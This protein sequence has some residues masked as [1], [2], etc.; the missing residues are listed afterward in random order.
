[1]PS[2]AGDD[3]TADDDM[4]ATRQMPAVQLPAPAEIRVSQ[5]IIAK[6]YRVMRELGRGT[7]GVVY[8]C[9]DL[10][11][12]QR[13]VVVKRIDPA[14]VHDADDLQ[15]RFATEIETLSSLRHP[16]I[17]TITDAGH[18]PD[19]AWFAMDLVDGM[20]LDQWLSETKPP[21]RATLQ[22]LAD[23]A[24]AVAY[25]HHRGVIHCD[26]KPDN[27][28]ID[29]EGRP[30]VLDFGLAK[31]LQ[32][33]PSGGFDVSGTPAYMAPEQ[34]RGEG[35][36]KASDCW[37]LGAILILAAT[38]R[39]PFDPAAPIETTL[40]T[41]AS[42]RL[43]RLTQ[44][45]LDPKLVQL[46]EQC[47][48]PHA[49]G[50]PS[51]QAI[52]EQ[53]SALADGQ[54]TEGL[55][56]A[57]TAW[58]AWLLLATAIVVAVGLI[59]LPM[60]TSSSQDWYVIAHGAGQ[61]TPAECEWL[62][63]FM[64]PSDEPLPAN[65]WLWFERAALGQD[66][67]LSFTVLAPSSHDDAVEIVLDAGRETGGEW[68]HLPPARLVKLEIG[69]SQMIRVGELIEGGSP[70]QLAGM[71]A[72]L[73]AG[74]AYH[75][76][77]ETVE[78]QLQVI[79]DGA[80]IFSY[81]SALP[82]PTGERSAVGLRWFK[83]TTEISGITIEQ[84]DRT[85]YPA[86]LASADLLARSATPTAAIARY[87][88][89]AAQYPDDDRRASALARAAT[90]AVVNGQ[91]D[92][93]EQL[94][95]QIE[96]EH[97]GDPA[98]DLAYQGLAKTYWQA[99]L[100]EQALDARDAISDRPLADLVIQALPG[101]RRDPLPP[102]IAGR[103]L[104]SLASIARLRQLDLSGLGLTSVLPLAGSDLR[105]L[106]LS[107]NQLTSCA[108]LAG[109]ALTNLDISFNPI[110][111]VTPLADSSIRKLTLAGCPIDDITPLQGLPLTGLDLNWTKVTDLRPIAHSGLTQLSLNSLALGE[112][113]PIATLSQLRRLSLTSCGVSDLS[114]VAGLPLV[115]LQLVNNPV[116]DLSVL[117]GMPLQRLGLDR[118]LVSDLS[119]LTDMSLTDLTAASTGVSDLSPL[120][121]MPLRQL[122]I[123]H[124]PVADL[125]PLRGLARLDQ[126][127]IEGSA[128]TDLTPLAQMRINTFDASH[129]QIRDFTPVIGRIDRFADLTGVP[130]LDLTAW[131]QAP[132]AHLSFAP[133]DVG[134]TAYADAVQAWSSS[135]PHLA[136]AM[137]INRLI[138]DQAVPALHREAVA[139]DDALVVVYAADLNRL[140]A[141]TVAQRLGVR[142]YQP[143]SRAAVDQL[144]RVL[145]SGH[146]GVWI[147]LTPALAQSVFRGL[148]DWLANGP[149]PAVLLGN[150]RVY[151]FADD[152]Q[153]WVAFDLTAT[154]SP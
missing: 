41:V 144:Q 36:T 2:G 113:A 114:I 105:S 138:Q 69:T 61:S 111:D 67:R 23:I 124:T 104:G 76:V 24:R 9:A 82:F 5:P 148:P 128:I 97:R 88:D 141:E 7:M 129:T 96:R 73:L 78:D 19:G 100:W 1:M 86:E 51:A 48:H 46:I 116:E 56:T 30:H 34:A 53:V 47:G 12:N 32:D 93:G 43:P 72:D 134:K 85:T 15:R 150:Q 63:H 120:A 42:G 68:W 137:T 117:R 64:Q 55:A 57:R 11:L 10:A 71:P 106:N 126:L 60:R 29:A 108:D 35:A 151:A 58:R 145:G 91:L 123:S 98:I 112:L 89:F 66:T 33:G 44:P 135:H 103:L 74:Q 99:G 90:V 25:A 139:I 153:H 127:D 101:L 17:V 27:I 75:V 4:H 52:A 16:G 122:R 20:P 119:P 110:T 131:Y 8:E 140:E 149:R 143:S 121:G 50:R 109:L 80:V 84:R 142:L 154:A 81:R 38:G 115:R 146:P 39:P 14:F 54:R 79:V 18:D 83:P 26:L 3:S 95:A 70:G 40:A 147:D 107:R 77:I 152:S 130:D 22:V 136:Q 31:R 87:R 37:S 125:S 92:L 65:G 6:R 28:V 59:A 94:I 49:D 13:P 102:V 21:P 133:N 45:D 62:T 132:P 118:T